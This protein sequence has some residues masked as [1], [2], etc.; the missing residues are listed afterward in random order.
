MFACN[1]H[2]ALFQFRTF[3]QQN[4]FLAVGFGG[5]FLVGIAV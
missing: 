1:I 4:L 3:I 2:S 5:G